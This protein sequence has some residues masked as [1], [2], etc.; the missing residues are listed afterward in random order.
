MTK[1]FTTLELS[2]L[3]NI[4]KTENSVAISYAKFDPDTGERLDDFVQQ[5]FPDQLTQEKVELQSRIDEIDALLAN[6]DNA[7][8]T[9]PSPADKI[10]P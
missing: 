6:I 10:L 8:I 5:I 1:D 2:G 9:P 3:A 7:Q 4:L